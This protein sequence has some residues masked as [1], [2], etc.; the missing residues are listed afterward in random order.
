MSKA[1]KAPRG[2]P[3]A[4]VLFHF[5]MWRERLRNALV[6][7]REGREFTH[8]SENVDELNDAE[9]PQGIGTPLADAAA[10]ADLLLGE[11]MEL[12]E[13]LG[14]RPFHWYAGTTTTEAVLRNSYTHPRLHLSEYWKENGSLDRSA[15][16]WE[17]ALT[18]LP[19]AGAPPR[20]LAN[21]QYNLA[22]IRALQGESDVALQLL[23]EALPVS[24]V[25]RDAAPKD[26]D[27]ESLHDDPRFQ[28][29]FKS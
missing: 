7:V 2:W 13:T 23:A 1:E 25:L 28:D 22:C 15:R 24:D 8:P 16:L 26:A 21:A 9:L 5:G 14:E 6:E 11:L 4:L 19:A 12:Y 10:R 17:G 3:A 29:L 20:F 18:E 27:F